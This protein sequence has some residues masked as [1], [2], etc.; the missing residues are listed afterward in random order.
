[1]NFV[2]A[3]DRRRADQLPFVT[4]ELPDECATRSGTGELVHRRASAPS[5]FE[6]AELVDAG[7]VR[8]A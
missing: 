6:D 1:M 4:I 7:K 2:P 3:R 8:V 5:A